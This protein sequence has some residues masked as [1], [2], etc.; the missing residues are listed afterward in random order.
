MKKKTINQWMRSL[1]R[2]LGF[3]AVGLVIIYSLSGITLIYRNTDFLKTEKV[4][5][6]TL[7]SQM[8]ATEVGAALKL[9]KMGVISENGEMINFENGT[10]NKVT[11]VA[12]YTTQEVVSPLKQFI[13]LHK[14]SSQSPFHW[15]GIA[16]GSILL[17]LVISSFWMFKP[18]SKMFKRGIIL[19]VSGVAVALVLLFV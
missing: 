10:Y 15:F 12:S 2:D 9:K 17:F 14:R 16:F 19:A 11:G 1:H 7:S 13:N 5:Q 6:K 18:G 3:F 4:M 8:S